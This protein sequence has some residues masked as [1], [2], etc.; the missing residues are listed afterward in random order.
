MH[1]PRSLAPP[2]PVPR[3]DLIAVLLDDAGLVQRSLAPLILAFVATACVPTP[4]DP[5]DFG[6]LCRPATAQCPSAVL[7][8][9]D[10][11]GR[12]QVDYVVRNVGPDPAAV[13]VVAL[14]PSADFGDGTGEIDPDDLVTRRVHE[15]VGAGK[16]AENRFTAQNLG[17]RD[18]FR[19]GVRCSGCEV[20]LDW[21]Y[22]SVP[23]EC[24]E[25]SNCPAGWA[26][27]ETLGRC[28]ECL[29]NADCNSDQRCNTESGRCDP[30]DTTA[31]C[32]TAAPSGWLWGLLALGLVWG[33][34]RR[35]C[36]A[37]LPFAL[38]LLV[39]PATVRASPPR[40]AI[41]LGAGPRVMAGALGSVTKRGIGLS[42]QQELR[43]RHIG[44]SLALGTSY[45]LTTQT[46]PPFSRSF[47]TYGVT[48]GPR[49]YAPIR[50]FELV[51]GPDY[52]RLGT[53]NNS[54]IR[55]TGTR[56]SFD[57]VGAVLG[58]RFRWSGL[59]VRVEGGGH[60]I[61]ALDTTMISVDL[62]VGFT[63]AQ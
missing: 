14:V 43:W 24:F 19:F 7:L 53:A 58:A 8:E 38:A 42:V 52:R 20:E 26:C 12:N 15:A 46:P 55:L 27:D 25:T 56:T 40:A 51:A 11:S 30:P 39:V 16:I 1:L 33:S 50:L 61:V 45:F 63:N 35:R 41:A 62:A 29:V 5:L 60:Y 57:A 21:V 48:L 3:D 9:R 47:Q 18:A 23:R 49:F 59:E 54:L 10:V 32:A 36:R 22:A 6:S 37:A 2:S 28:A 34:C 44:A 13:E 31:G 4:E 17:V